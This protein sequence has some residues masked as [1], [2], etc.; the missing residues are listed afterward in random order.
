MRQVPGRGMINHGPS[1]FEIVV[2]LFVVALVL[3][4]GYR[5]IDGRSRP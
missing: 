1:I 5:L 2:A 3:Y 4:V